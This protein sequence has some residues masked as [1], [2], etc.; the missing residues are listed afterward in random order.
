MATKDL[1]ET[2]LKLEPADR[3]ALADEILRSLERPD[4]AVDALWIEEAQRRL[5]AFRRGEASTFE[6]EDVVGSF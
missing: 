1:L 6:A 5:A 2:A 4:P 3:F